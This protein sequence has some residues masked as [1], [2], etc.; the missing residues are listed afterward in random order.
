MTQILVIDS[1]L[2]PADMSASRR[3]TQQLVDRLVAQDPSARVVRRDLAVN[4]LGHIGLDL[5]AGTMT[6][7]EGRSAVQAKAVAASD[8]LIAELF[9]AD[10]IVIGAPMYNFAIPSTLKAWIDHLCIAGKTF[11]YSAAGP[12]GLVKGKR[13]FV[14]ASRGGMYTEGPMAGFNFQDPYLRTVLGFL[15]MTDVTVITAEQ[16]KMG[17]DAQAAGFAR[18]DKLMNEALRVAQPA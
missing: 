18:A 13:V 14:V 7:A 17:P 16:Q 2:F 11:S 5:M 15:G 8:E 12:E 1:S 9:A 4:P 10:V 3:V 6:P